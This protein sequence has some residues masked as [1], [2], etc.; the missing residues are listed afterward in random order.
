[1]KGEK[2]LMV[3]PYTDTYYVA[4]CSSADGL[5][6]ILSIISG[7]KWGFD[8]SRLQEYRKKNQPLCHESMDFALSKIGNVAFSGLV[9][10]G[11]I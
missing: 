1:M 2:P 11:I 4:I 7:Y 10:M 6:S 8:L 5:I 3:M 9:S